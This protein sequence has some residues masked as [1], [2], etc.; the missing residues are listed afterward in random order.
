[1]LNVY[2]KTILRE[3]GESVYMPKD[4]KYNILLE[5]NSFIR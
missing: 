4:G 5:L 3:R 2:Q 1:M